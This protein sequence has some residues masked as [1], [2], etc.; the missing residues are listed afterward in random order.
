M[1]ILTNKYFISAAVVVVLAVLLE[2]NTQG[3]VEIVTIA[4]VAGSVALAVHALKT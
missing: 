2:E 1:K 4:A 3:A